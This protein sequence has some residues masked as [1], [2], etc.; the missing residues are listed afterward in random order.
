[1]CSY[2]TITWSKSKSWRTTQFQLIKHTHTLYNVLHARSSARVVKADQSTAD[3]VLQKV[4]RG[5]LAITMSA[6]QFSYQ[7]VGKE[8]KEQVCV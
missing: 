2:P 4:Q 7:P 6:Y 3:A 8:E 5:Q 1:M